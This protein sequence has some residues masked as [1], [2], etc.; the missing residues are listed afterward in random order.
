[1]PGK[2]LKKKPTVSIVK[3]D[4]YNLD[5]VY[6]A[7]KKCLELIGGLDTIVRHDDNVF[8]KINHLPP[9]SPPERGIITHP[10]FVQSV[11][12]LLKKYS[13]NITVGDDIDSDMGD[14][15]LVSGIRQVCEKAETR[16]INQEKRDLWRSDA[17]GYCLKSFIYRE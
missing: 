10:V 13:V 17:M 12:K 5:K 6:E 8:V 15:F 16:L 1:M 9:P 14:G 11:L 4:D 7:V 2:N 3:A